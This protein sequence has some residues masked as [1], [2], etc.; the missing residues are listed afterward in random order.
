MVEALRIGKLSGRH[1]DAGGAV[2]LVA[3]GQ[4]QYAW[5][6]RSRTGLFALSPPVHPLKP[7]YFFY[8]WSEG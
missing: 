6:R 1:E 4:H 3:G 2:V 5:R 7:T 8:L